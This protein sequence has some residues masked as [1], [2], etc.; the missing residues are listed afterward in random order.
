MTN[1]Y[2]DLRD[3]PEGLPTP[4]SALTIGAHPDDVEFGAGGTLARWARTDAG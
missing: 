4:E 2:D 1:L 3:A